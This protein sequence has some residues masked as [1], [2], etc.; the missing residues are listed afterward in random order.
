MFTRIWCSLKKGSWNC[1]RNVD[2]ILAVSTVELKVCS[3]SMGDSETL[4]AETSA[5]MSYNSAGYT[6]A[7]YADAGTNAVPD[8]SAFAS[9]T[10]GGYVAPGQSADAAYSVPGV[11]DG[12]AY[13]MDPNAVMQQAPGVGAP[14]SGDNVATSENEA[15]GS[16]QAA[17]YNSM[18][19][20]VVNEA[21][22]ATSTENGTSLGIE[23]G[24]AAGQELVDGSGMY[25]FSGMVSCRA[26]LVTFCSAICRLL[27]Q[28][29]IIKLKSALQIVLV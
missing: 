29:I 10:T 14:G 21:G 2:S 4:V 3:S 28:R 13:N 27:F 22:N 7:A 9:G 25:V 12:N 15:M 24:A 18:N 8:A 5:V 23:S 11:A 6:N 19:G 16:S 17:G 1:D 20:N 26:V